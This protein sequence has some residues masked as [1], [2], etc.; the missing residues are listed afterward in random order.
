MIGG[1][2][3]VQALHMIKCAVDYTAARFHVYSSSVGQLAGRFIS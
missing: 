1:Q 2:E 3:A